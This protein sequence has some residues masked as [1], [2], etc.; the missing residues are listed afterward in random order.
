MT[1][2]AACEYN[3]DI[4][5][6]YMKI[7]QVET[8]LAVSRPIMLKWERMGI[9]VPARRNGYR[10][11][12]RAGVVDMIMNRNPTFSRRRIELVM[13]RSKALYRTGEVA[14]LIGVARQT[15]N[16]WVRHDYLEPVIMREVRTRYGREEWRFLAD[17]VDDLI[18]DR[19]SRI[20]ER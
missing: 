2:A 14:K 15:I 18:A 3:K 20:K 9:L 19:L 6:Q 13:R 7:S 4:L 16:Y 8:L 11:Y 12:S 5:N 1:A 10:W 17:K